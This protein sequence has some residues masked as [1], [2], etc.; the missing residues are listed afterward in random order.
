MS[1]A[2]LSP[3]AVRELL[4]SKGWT[5]VDLAAVWGHSTAYISWLVNHPAERSPVYHDAFHGLPNRSSVEVRLEGRHKPRPR[6]RAWSIRDMYPIGRVFVAQTNAL[7]IEE[8]TEIAVRSVSKEGDQ[9][10]V[11]FEVL[12]GADRLGEICLPHGPST[13]QLS[14]TG[15]DKAERLI[16][17]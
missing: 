4:R 15:Q 11:T 1:R 6:K 3:K 5:N 2:P 7:G 14:D 12:T 13:D 9:H 10:L 17:A 8:G 16:A